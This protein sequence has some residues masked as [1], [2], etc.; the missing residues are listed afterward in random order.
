MATET[1]EEPSY[2]GL[3]N[4]ISLG[5]SAAGIYLEAWANATEDEELA[6][7]LRFVAARESSHGEVFGRRIG[8]L[9][10][11]L[12]PKPDMEAQK[13]LARYANPK[14]SD[15]EKLG[16][17]ETDFSSFFEDMER[18]AAE[19]VFDPLTAKLMLWYIGE[20]RDSTTVLRDTAARIRTA[21]KAKA[22]PMNGISSNG[23]GPTSDAVAIMD[24]MTS[25]FDRLE[26]ALEKFVVAGELVGAGRRSRN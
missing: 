4:D 15:A 10:F 14:I 9:G 22:M 7:G 23:T 19:G 26:K 20:E 6:R 1:R 24:C 2:L 16:P 11:E 5:E 17:D 3:L 21:A 18:Q 13:R 8:E 12:R 25:G